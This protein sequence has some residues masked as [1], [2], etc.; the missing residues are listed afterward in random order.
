MN[1][2]ITHVTGSHIDPPNLRNSTR[3]SITA[4]PPEP[5]H[6]TQQQQVLPAPP[7]VLDKPSRR[8]GLIQLLDQA[9]CTLVLAFAALVHPHPSDATQLAQVLTSCLQAALILAAVAPLVDLK[10]FLY[11]TAAG[12]EVPIANHAFLHLAI[13]GQAHYLHHH[14]ARVSSGRHV[15]VAGRSDTIQALLRVPTRDRCSADG[16]SVKC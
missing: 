4:P 7:S 14:A 3:H 8:T 6:T 2:K 11:A 15:C 5:P 16:V 12:V 9:S 1:A 10:S 13:D